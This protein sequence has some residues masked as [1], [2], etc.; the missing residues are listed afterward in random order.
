MK[1]EL[2]LSQGVILVLCGLAANAPAFHLV[3]L[4]Q[5]YVN[6]VEGRVVRV[7]GD[8]QFQIRYARTLAET[9]FSF[10]CNILVD[11]CFAAEA[12]RKKH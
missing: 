3:F 1:S 8:A 5:T 4:T 6:P 7:S 12:V 11:F 9:F 10:S 2:F